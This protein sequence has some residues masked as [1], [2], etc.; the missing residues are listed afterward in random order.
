MHINDLS[1]CEVNQ[2]IISIMDNAFKQLHEAIA[3]IYI[4]D[5]LTEADLEQLS[6]YNEL[7]KMKS[8]SDNLLKK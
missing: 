2:R 1:T 8:L 6:R 3:G 5:T 7:L 4:V